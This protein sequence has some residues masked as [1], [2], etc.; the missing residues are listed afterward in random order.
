MWHLISH[1]VCST[2]A[3]NGCD[4][5]RIAPGSVV[6]RAFDEI[7]VINPT[8][9]SRTILVTGFQASTTPE[10]LIIH[11]QRKKYGGGDIESIAVSNRGIA[12]I[13]FDKPEGEIGYYVQFLAN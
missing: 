10:D 3:A 2:M 4:T 7:C 6:V 11:F 12:V 13:T 1:E 9:F 5:E 8:S